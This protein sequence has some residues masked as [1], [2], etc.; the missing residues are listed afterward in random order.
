MNAAVP[1]ADLLRL[2]GLRSA[3]TLA[4]LLPLCPPTDPQIVDLQVADIR[5]AAT[6]RAPQEAS[7]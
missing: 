1:L 4:D 2:A 3:R 5:D 7:A 6:P